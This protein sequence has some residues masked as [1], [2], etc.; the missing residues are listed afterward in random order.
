MLRI[1]YGSRDHVKNISEK[2]NKSDFSAQPRSIPEDKKQNSSLI[3]GKV[4]VY[5][6]IVNASRIPIT[7]VQVVVTKMD[8]KI[9]D[10]KSNK[11][12]YWEARLPSGNYKIS[13][14]HNDF[15]TINREVSIPNNIS[16]YEVR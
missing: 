4:K 5:G 1:E 12:G 11:E 15:K 13:Y 6:Y 3:L 10:L 14:I 9:R 8:K 16:V 2:D 7:G